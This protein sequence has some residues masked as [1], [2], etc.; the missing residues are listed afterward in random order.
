MEED[1]KFK[2]PKKKS[3]SKKSNEAKNELKQKS[4]L[5]NNGIT[6][7]SIKASQDEIHE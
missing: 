3:G 6:L 2:E 1:D 7:N 4:D 5:R